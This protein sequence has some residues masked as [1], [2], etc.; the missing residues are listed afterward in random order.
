MALSGSQRGNAVGSLL[1][2]GSGLFRLFI[3][4]PILVRHI[5]V[6]TYASW[7][8]AAEF[9]SYVALLE[10]GSSLAAAT[11]VAGN[12]DLD[13]H[14][15][16][17]SVRHISWIL[18][19]TAT[20][21]LIACSLALSAVVGAGHGDAYLTGVL[22]LLLGVPSVCYVATSYSYGILIGRGR[23]LAA[24]ISVFA[25][26]AVAAA[27]VIAACLAG[28]TPVELAV[29]WVVPAGLGYLGLLRLARRERGG[30]PVTVQRAAGFRRQGWVFAGGFATWAVAG[31]L[32]VG[33]D[34]TIVAA[35]DLKAV[36]AYA[37]AASFA[38]LVQAGLS[39]LLAPMSSPDT[40]LRFRR[41]AGEGAA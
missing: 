28:A 7:A 13:P 40:Q 25:G 23:L 27:L 2:T 12:A 21:L 15:I 11:L 9:A 5:G 36:S 33:L 22:V 29:C 31:F 37:I 39:A 41:R 34:T 10:V 18:A 1:A 8:L 24:G 14:E 16:G 4:P 38:L 20:V 26:R 6:G 35:T 32:V 19:G 30:D 17:R 3:L